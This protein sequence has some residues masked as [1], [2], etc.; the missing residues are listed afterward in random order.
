MTFRF[1]LSINK[2]M[3]RRLNIRTRLVCGR[4]QVIRTCP[5][6]SPRYQTHRVPRVGHQAKSSITI[7]DPTST[8]PW[9]LRRWTQRITR[10]IRIC[11]VFVIGRGPLRVDLDVPA[12]RYW[13][14]RYRGRKTESESENKPNH[15]LFCTRHRA[16]LAL[17][18]RSRSWPGSRPGG[19][20]KSRS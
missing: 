3:L 6:T 9:S 13:Y 19:W 16:Q 12:A 10:C 18:A 1:L 2:N 14:L 8:S 4:Q 7:P 11:T 5:A 20:S 17:S 15:R